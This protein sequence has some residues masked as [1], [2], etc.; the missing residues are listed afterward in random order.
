MHE[1]SIMQSILDI[2]LEYAGKNNARKVNRIY[3]KIGELSG[4]IPDWM[5]RYFDFVSEGTIADKAEVIIEW[6]PG[7]IKCG[8]CGKEYQVTKEEFDFRCPVCGDCSDI[9]I[10]SGREYNL[11]SI[12]VD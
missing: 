12:E 8:S 2:V 3:L 9:E 1:L 6:A 4:F 10:I 11:T 5:Q 7:M